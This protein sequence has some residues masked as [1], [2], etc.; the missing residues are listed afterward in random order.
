MKKLVCLLLVAA[1]ALTGTPAWS[2]TVAEGQDSWP[3]VFVKRTGGTGDVPARLI[4]LNEEAVTLLLDDRQVVMP[5]SDVLRIQKSG[6]SLWNG[7]LIGGI[8]LGVWCAMICGQGLNEAGQLPTTVVV[9]GA[10]GALIGAGIDAMHKGRTTIYT[11]PAASG[12]PSGRI[13]G[14]AFTI[15]WGRAG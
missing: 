7:A 5:L 1:I 15:R 12:T 14:I 4:H 13:R 8:V 9:N 6:D 11:R 2:Q 10:V 3:L